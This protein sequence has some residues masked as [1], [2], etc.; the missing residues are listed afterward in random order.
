MKTTPKYSLFFNLAH[1]QNWHFQA[2][3]HLSAPIQQK[4]AAHEHTP[5]SA[6]LFPATFSSQ[7]LS[8]RASRVHKRCTTS[9]FYWWSVPVAAQTW[10]KGW[11]K[12]WKIRTQMIFS[13]NDVFEK[14]I[15]R[16]H[17][18]SHTNYKMLRQGVFSQYSY[19]CVYVSGFQVLT[20]TQ[21]AIACSTRTL[22]AIVVLS[23]W[24]MADYRYI[25]FSH[26][27]LYS[28]NSPLL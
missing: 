18:K 15:G 10:Q 25:D 11:K 28:T 22:M 8:D 19:F 26:I 1:A 24:W 3:W 14:K 20:R 4:T 12:K 2:F 23:A 13:T 6:P 16:I 17:V 27:T 5:P 9:K 7:T 21:F